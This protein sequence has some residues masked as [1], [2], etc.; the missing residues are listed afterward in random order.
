MMVYSHRFQGLIQQLVVELE[1]DVILSD[2][3]SPVSLR[4]NEVTLNQVADM[5]N[6]SMKKVATDNGRVLFKFQKV[7]R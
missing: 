2:E 7:A 4:E 6:V 1:L 3:N 5:L